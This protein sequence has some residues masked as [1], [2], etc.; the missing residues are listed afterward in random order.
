MQFKR[1]SK[2]KALKSVDEFYKSPKDPSKYR[3]LCKDCWYIQSRK[4]LS[5]HPKKQ[6]EYVIRYREKNNGYTMDK[7]TKCSSYL[8]I[9]IAESL[10]SKVFNNVERMPNN[11]PGYD[12]ICGKGYKIDVKSSCIRYH[13]NRAGSWD[14]NIRYNKIPDY[15][16][17]IAFDNRE[18]LNPQHIWI[19]P[20]NVLNYKRSLTI[21]TSTIYKWETYE[22]SINNVIAYCDTLKAT[23]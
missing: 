14:F 6:R 22:R 4:W 2:C 7:N 15:F 19:I 16:L 1:C 21:S 23:S 20:G 8:G 5:E 11:N 13:C 3:S 10:L 18:N 17:L 12:F 9:Y